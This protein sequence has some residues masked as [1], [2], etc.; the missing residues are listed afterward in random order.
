M[1]LQGRYVIISVGCLEIMDSCILDGVIR[2]I[3]DVL[4]AICIQLLNQSEWLST[5]ETD[6]I[7]RLQM[8]ANQLLIAVLNQFHGLMIL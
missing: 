8:N 6:L 5:L 1:F 7:M 2:M 3:M 4:G